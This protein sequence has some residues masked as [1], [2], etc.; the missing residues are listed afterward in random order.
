MVGDVVLTPMPFT[1]L[2][3][4]KIRPV[5]VI[6]DVG[7]Q[8]WI[9]CQITSRFPERIRRIELTSRDMQSGSI[10]VTSY[11][12]PDRLFTLNENVFRRTVGRLSDDKLEDVKAAVRGLF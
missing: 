10:R 5:V 12:R 1:D 9:V 3:E 8:D 7:M 6:A 2:S 4:Q 11:V